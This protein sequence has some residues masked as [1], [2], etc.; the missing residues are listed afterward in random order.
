MQIVLDN[1][2]GEERETSRDKI[3]VLI[4]MFINVLKNK[5][6]LPSKQ[7]ECCHVDVFPDLSFG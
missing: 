2:K 4:L 3:A 6:F 1:T 7:C 5:A